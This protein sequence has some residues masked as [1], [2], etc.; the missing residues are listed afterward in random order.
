M[1]RFLLPVDDNEERALQAAETVTS[2]PCDPADVHVTVLNV[3]ARVDVSGPS[4]HVSS[5]EW[6]DEDA[7]PD[8]VA[9]VREYLDGT[10]VSVDTRREHADP[11]EEIVRVASELDADRIVMAGRKRTPIGK[12]LF[13]SVTQ[14]VLIH[15]D[16][17][18]TV[19]GTA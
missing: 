1:F 15:A 16:T 8:S 5:E 3:Q 9:A 18:V 14:S 13:G 6:Y 7:V 2:I 12:V 19:I 10:G 17:P 11:A 4:G